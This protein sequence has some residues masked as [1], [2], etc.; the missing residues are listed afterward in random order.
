MYSLMTQSYVPL[1]VA[2]YTTDILLCVHMCIDTH[3]EC[4]PIYTHIVEQ[5]DPAARSI[6]AI[7]QL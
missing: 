1:S 7:G 3:C 4:M 6:G 5:V 2:R